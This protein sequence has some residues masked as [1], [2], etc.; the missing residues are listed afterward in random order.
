[1]PSPIAHTATAYFIY[2]LNLSNPRS[3]IGETLDIPYI[4]LLGNLADLD[5]LPQ[6]FFQINSHRGPSHSLSIALLVSVVCAMLY[7][8]WSPATVQKFFWLTLGLYISH[9]FLDFWTAG[10]RG[11]QLFWPF[12]NQYFMSSIP[13]FPRVRHSEGLF[14]QGHLIFIAFELVYSTCLYLILKQVKRLRRNK[15]L[16]Q[17]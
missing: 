10:G 6:L 13:F 7:R 8:W 4:V 16:N 14:Y 9:L 11:I 15:N 3:F 5:F 1:M 17:L 12:S 2:K